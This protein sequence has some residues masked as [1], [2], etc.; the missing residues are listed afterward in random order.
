MGERL[1]LLDA[2]LVAVFRVSGLLMRL[3]LYSLTDSLNG[4]P[5]LAAFFA[6]VVFFAVDGFMMFC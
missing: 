4:M 2:F 3:R 5:F 1:E 6:G